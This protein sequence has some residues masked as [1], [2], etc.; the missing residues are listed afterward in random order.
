MDPTTIE[1]LVRVVANCPG[2][3]I[4]AL[5]THRDDYRAE[6]L[7]GPAIRRVALQKLA[8]HECEQMVAAVAGSDFCRAGLPARSWNEPTACHSLSRSLRG[9]VVDSGAVPL[10]ARALCRAGSCGSCAGKYSRFTDGAP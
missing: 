2:E 3:R 4:M 9:P 6:W 7:S 1:L 5:I 10:A 8:V